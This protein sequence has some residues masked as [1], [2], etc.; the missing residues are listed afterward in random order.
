MKKDAIVSKIIGS[1]VPTYY[2]WKREQRP[3]I[4]L[5]EKY[6]SKEELEEFLQN[7]KINKFEKFNFINN[8]I[9]E[10]NRIKY[11]KSFTSDNP[12]G[13]LYQ[14]H[15]TFIKFYFD[16]IL[17]LKKDEEFYKK[18]FDF[19]LNQYILIFSIE[20]YQYNLDNDFDN[21]EEE[22]EKNYRELD[23]TLDCKILAK[24]EIKEISKLER[25]EKYED[26]YKHFNIFNN[27]DSSM[28]LFLDECINNN[29]QNLLNKDDA[30]KF[31]NEAQYHIDKFSDC[32][33]K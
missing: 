13:S 25:V 17:E 33:S 14:S 10:K 26:L 23:E 22:I 21:M 7:E 11:L 29:F 6:F 4:N 27:W 16:F 31:Q 5:L 28:L 15:S 3:I 18:D 32:N 8:E 20:N 2:N 12:F 30:Q 19:L 1:S 24:N 9:L